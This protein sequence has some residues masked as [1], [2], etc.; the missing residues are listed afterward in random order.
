MKKPIPIFAEEQALNENKR[1]HVFEHI[2]YIIWVLA[3]QMCSEDH[4]K[5]FESDNWNFLHLAKI[6]VKLDNIMKG[7]LFRLQTLALSNVTH[8]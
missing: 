7:Y 1:W 6:I 2:I 4:P 5:K 8:I 3:K